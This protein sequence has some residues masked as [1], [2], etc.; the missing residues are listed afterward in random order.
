M[1]EKFKFTPWNEERIQK[2]A[3]SISKYTGETIKRIFENVTIKEQGF[4]PPLAVL[5]LSNKYSEARLEAACEFAII[6]GTRKPRY[7][8]LSSILASNQDQ[9]YLESRKEKKKSD[10]PMGYLRGSS[11]YAGGGLND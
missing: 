4:N 2:W 9:I 8:H 3:D 5:R 6:S 7:H 11:Y 10:A 1:P